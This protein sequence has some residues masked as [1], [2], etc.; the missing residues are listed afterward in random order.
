MQVDD[1]LA[2]FFKEEI[3]QDSEEC[4][5]VISECLGMLL[6]VHPNQVIDILKQRITPEWPTEVRCMA[7]TAFRHATSEQFHPISDALATVLPQVLTTYLVDDNLDVKA[8]TIRLLSYA[9]NYKKKLITPYLPEIFPILIRLTE[10]DPGLVRVINLGPFKHKVDDGLKIRKASFE[11]L[12]VLMS[13]CYSFID[14]NI[15][16]NALLRGLRDEYDVK[17]RC[18]GLMAD[19]SCFAPGVVMA[20]LDQ[21]VEPLT[22]TLTAR[23]K[24]DAVTQEIDRNKDLQRSCLRAVAALAS[25]PGAMDNPAFKAFMDQTVKAEDMKQRYE[26]IEAERMSTEAI[27]ASVDGHASRQGFEFMDTSL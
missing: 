1:V 7:I 3:V 26:E 21:L 12:G 2:L 8:T 6:L 10:R 23:L 11:C 27:I 5:T 14:P 19:L 25:L 17:I 13:R 15:L 4:R 18:H 16:F 20:H 24:S 22:A 9:G